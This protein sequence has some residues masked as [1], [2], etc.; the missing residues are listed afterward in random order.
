MADFE[1]RQGCT[2][3][4]LRVT[5]FDDAGRVDFPTKFPGGVTFKMVIGAIII[6]GAATGDSSGGLSY[7]WAAHDL[8]ITGTGSV[9]FHGTDGAGRVEAFPRGRNLSIII[10]PDL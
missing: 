5:A 9:L 2:H 10:I 7:Q 4:P 1:F 8:D 6:T 3:S